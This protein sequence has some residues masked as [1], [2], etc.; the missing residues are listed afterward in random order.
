MKLFNFISGLLGKAQTDQMAKAQSLILEAL[1]S[2]KR[3]TSY[4]AN[5]IGHT[6]DSR[7]V[8]SRLRK[9]GYAI[10]DKWVTGITGK[11]FKV[12]WMA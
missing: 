6:V 10:A 4:Q 9:N 3:I 12:Y 8:I 1:K 7:V 5:K 11:R 2:G